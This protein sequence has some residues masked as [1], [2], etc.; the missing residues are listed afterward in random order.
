LKK[1]EFGDQLEKKVL[2]IKKP[3]HLGRQLSEKVTGEAVVA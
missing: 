2:R 3:P 1:K